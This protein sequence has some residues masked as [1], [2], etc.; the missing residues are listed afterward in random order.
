[1]YL[2]EYKLDLKKKK[3]AGI[4]AM[5][6][7][8]E[9]AIL[10]NFIRLSKETEYTHLNLAVNKEQ[11]IITGPAMIPDIKIYRT[12]ESLGLDDDGFIYFTKDTIKKAAHLFLEN[13]N[14]NMV[15]LGHEEN[16]TDLKLV[17]SWIVLNSLNDKASALGFEVPEGTWMISYKVNND[18]L[19]ERIKAGEF[20]GFSIEA[21][22]EGVPV[23]ELKTDSPI[24]VEDIVVEE[25]KELTDDEILALFAEKFNARRA[26]RK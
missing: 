1:M 10:T 5:S 14:Q 21:V 25:G 3:K 24:H 17:E 6:I 13:E 11:K 8:D 7:V 15:T 23:Q 22:F 26:K 16:N 12:A 9:P 2:I 19:W 18:E 20:K 4:Y